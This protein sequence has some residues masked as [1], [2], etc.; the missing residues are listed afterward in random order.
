MNI[1]ISQFDINSFYNTY[2]RNSM[3]GIIGLLTVSVTS[4]KSSNLDLLFRP[5][6]YNYK[7]G[8]QIAFSFLI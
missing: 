6:N 2:L 1:S 3:P 7:G 8:F 5:E 4:I